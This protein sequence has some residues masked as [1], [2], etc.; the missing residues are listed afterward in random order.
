M[1][2]LIRKSHNVSVL[3]YQFVCP[4]KYRRIVFSEEVDTTLKDICLEISK[5]Y[6]IHF[7]KIGT[8]HSQYPNTAPQRLLT[9]L[10]A[11]LP[12]RFSNNTQKSRRSCGAVS[13]GQMVILSGV[14]EH[15][16]MSK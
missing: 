13:S 5:R 11:L 1:S 16:G 8:D 2:D 6:E 14:W 12:R 15:M 9:L 10:K 4:A 7:V 3:L